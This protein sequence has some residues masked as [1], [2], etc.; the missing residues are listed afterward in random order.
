MSIELFGTMFGALM[1]LSM[2]VIILILRSIDSK[3]IVN[4]STVGTY[5]EAYKQ[6]PAHPS[7][8]GHPKNGIPCEKLLLK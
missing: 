5:R 7:L 2:G 4:C 6:L 1:L 3:M 8:D